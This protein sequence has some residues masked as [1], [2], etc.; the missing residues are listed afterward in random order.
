MHLSKARQSS[1]PPA[2]VATLH[3]PFETRARQSVGI[4]YLVFEPNGRSIAVLHRRRETHARQSVGILNLSFESNGRSGYARS[5][6]AHAERRASA[7]S[8]PTRYKSRAA[9]VPGRSAPHAGWGATAKTTTQAAHAPAAEAA[10]TVGASD[11]ATSLSKDGLGRTREHDR[12]NKYK[13]EDFKESG[14]V[15]RSCPHHRLGP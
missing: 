5:A 11:N 15:H 9:G 12:G 10:A 14:F 4:L 13:K 1:Q 3:L 6:G 8:W 2:G 7:E